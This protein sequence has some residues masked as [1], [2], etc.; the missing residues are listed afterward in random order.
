MYL[1]SIIK[2][3]QK[4]SKLANDAARCTCGPVALWNHGYPRSIIHR[5]CHPKTKTSNK[6][7]VIRSIW[8]VNKIIGLHKM[9]NGDCKVLRNGDF[10]ENVFCRRVYLWTN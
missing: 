3:L 10:N 9:N 2:C 4:N 8:C 5:L 6:N 7:L 1:F